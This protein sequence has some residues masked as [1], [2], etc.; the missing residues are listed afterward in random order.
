MIHI[1]RSQKSTRDQKYIKRTLSDFILV[2]KN[3]RE[4]KCRNFKKIGSNNL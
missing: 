4:L 3:F 2:E 1:I